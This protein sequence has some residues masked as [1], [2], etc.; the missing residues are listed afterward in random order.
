MIWNGAPTSEQANE[1]LLAEMEGKL[2]FAVQLSVA[3]VKINLFPEEVFAPGTKSC[4][5]AWVCATY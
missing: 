3:V 1:D 4:A 2:L 5:P